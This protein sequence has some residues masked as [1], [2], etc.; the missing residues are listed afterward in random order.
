MKKVAM[1]A[2]VVVMLMGV[3]AMTGCR[4]E[5]DEALVGTWEWVFIDD[6]TYVFNADGTGT[7]GFTGAREGFTWSTNND[8]LRINRNSAPSG[9]VR[10]ERWTYSIENN[11]LTIVSRH[12]AG[13][14][15]SYRRLDN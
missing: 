10:N 2:L 1:V 14:E 11:V 6:Y 4:R 9:E 8:E 5:Q 7:R 3:A 13:L 12:E 15:Y